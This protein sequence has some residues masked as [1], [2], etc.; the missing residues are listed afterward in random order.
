MLT[1]ADGKPDLAQANPA[2]S[3][4][5]HWIDEGAQTRVAA[6]GVARKIAALFG[7]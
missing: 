7:R 2:A 1:K 3:A 4:G 6:M 5:V